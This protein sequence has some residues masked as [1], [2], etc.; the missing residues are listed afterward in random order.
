M[1][2]IRHWRQKVFH[3]FPL[4]LNNDLMSLFRGC[5]EPR[6]PT[7]SGRTL[8]KD[9]YFSVFLE[10]ALSKLS[11]VSY[12]IETSNRNRVPSEETWT[13]GIRSCPAI[14][15]FVIGER[16]DLRSSST[17]SAWTALW[18][19]VAIARLGSQL[20]RTWKPFSCSFVHLRHFLEGKDDQEYPLS[21][22]RSSLA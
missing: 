17:R 15:V 8:P 21:G 2:A 16:P 22:S 10:C 7:I 6:E 18:R 11:R 12:G 13:S 19:L 9:L 3:R 14:A 1:A 4:M 5:Q 20:L